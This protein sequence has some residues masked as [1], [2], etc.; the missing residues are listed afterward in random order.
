MV[1]GGGFL[2]FQPRLYGRCDHQLLCDGID[3]MKR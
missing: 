1:I 3:G 2:M